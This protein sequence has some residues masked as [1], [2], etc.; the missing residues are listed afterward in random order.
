MTKSWD[1]IEASLRMALDGHLDQ[2]SLNLWINGFLDS[3]PGRVL[4]ASLMI[5]LRLQRLSP[6]LL[7]DILRGAKPD[8]NDPLRTFSE[9]VERHPSYPGGVLCT[10]ICGDRFDGLA[11]LLDLE[12]FFRFYVLPAFGLAPTSKSRGWAQ[13]RLENPLGWPLG[14]V[15]SAWRGSRPLAWVTRR[16]S[17]SP[18]ARSDLAASELNDALGLGLDESTQ[19]IYV[20]YPENP[21]SPI[22]CSVPTAL[23]PPWSSSNYWFISASEDDGWG[24]TQSVSGLTSGLPERVHR[25]LSSLSDGFLGFYLGKTTA[26]TPNV[27]ALL[28]EALGRAFEI[29]LRDK[30]ETK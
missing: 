6:T 15:T 20:L 29:A 27:A 12:S 19:L 2:T 7:S 10:C 1:A 17:I 22:E 24:R 28:N 3:N 4:A 30:L 18:S 9:L 25:S 5:D 11:R 26:L 23:D 21:T 16:D 8:R 14:F 13:S